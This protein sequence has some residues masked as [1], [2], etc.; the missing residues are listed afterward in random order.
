M[1]EPKIPGLSSVEVERLKTQN[2]N[3]F[4]RLSQRIFGI[5]KKQQGSNISVY[6]P[7]IGELISVAYRDERTGFFQGYTEGHRSIRLESR[8]SDPEEPIAL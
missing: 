5:V 8:K 7:E 3:E 6:Y 1:T 4:G 2:K